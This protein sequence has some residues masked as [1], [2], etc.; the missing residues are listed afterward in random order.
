MTVWFNLIPL[1]V[2]RAQ[3]RRRALRRWSAGLCLCAVAVGMALGVGHRQQGRIGALSKRLEQLRANVTHVR[4]ELQQTT[5]EVVEI[6]SRLDRAR[7]IRRKR[8]WTGL[9]ETVASVLPATC[10]LSSFATVPERPNAR[11][12]RVEPR[13]PAVGA[14][15]P[16]KVQQ[17]K[18]VTLDAPRE[19]KLSGFALDAAEPQRIV[20]RLKKTGLFR[21]V[22]LE[23]VERGR[24]RMEDVFRFSVRCTW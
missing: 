9:L 18:T 3:A 4:A 6:K 24:G 15:A 1:P 19:L 12:V 11:A 8:A 20:A 21:Q 17:A 22:T 5:A 16:E 14:A 10:W 23:D 13:R 7:A 2:Q